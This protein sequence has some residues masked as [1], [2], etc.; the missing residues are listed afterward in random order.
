MYLSVETSPFIRICPS[1]AL[2]MATD[3]AVA[4]ASSGSCTIA[5]FPGS[6]PSCAQATRIFASSPTSV[7]S[8]MPRST[9]C[10]TAP[11]VCESL[12]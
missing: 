12:A 8:T 4:A 9:A 3:R 6:I 10:P 11:M 1:P 5:N 2:T 7:A